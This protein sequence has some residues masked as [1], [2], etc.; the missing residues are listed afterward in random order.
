MLKCH[1]CLS[2]FELANEAK[3]TMTQS[4]Y[5]D[6][7]FPGESITFR[8][9]LS[10]SFG[11]DYVWYHNGSEIQ[12]SKS[13]YTITHIEHH[14]SGGYYCKAK[15][16]K[17]PFYTSPS[18]TTTLQVSGKLGLHERGMMPSTFLS[19]HLGFILNFNQDFIDFLPLFQMCLNLS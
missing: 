2:F 8:C 6:V 16:G 1:H 3:P 11:W 9:I 12:T 17:D 18:E 5:F 19:F 14:N 13:S 4:S 7:M 10:V 15:R